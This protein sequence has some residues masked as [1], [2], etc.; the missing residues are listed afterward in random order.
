MKYRTKGIYSLLLFLAPGIKQVILKKLILISAIL[1]TAIMLQGQ[2]INVPADYTAIQEG[3]AAANQGD[4]VLVEPGTY[5]EN[6]NFLGKDITVASMYLF[7]RD[8]SIISQTI[9]DG[10]QNG[11]VVTFENGVTRDALLCGFTITNG[12]VDALE[13]GAGI[14]CESSDPSL[15][16]LIIS[17]NIVE[18][19]GDVY[20]VGI[21]CFN[22]FPYLEEIDIAENVIWETMGCSGLGMF[23]D[24]FS[25]AILKNVIIRNN[26]VNSYWGGYGGQLVF[27]NGENVELNNV[28][29]YSNGTF[30]SGIIIFGGTPKLI[31]IKVHGCSGSSGSIGLSGS[32]AIIINS[33]FT[34]NNSYGISASDSS[35]ILLQNV[36]IAGNEEY[37]IKVG[38][39]ELTLINCIVW[40]NGIEVYLTSDNSSISVLNSDIKGGETGI[41]GA[42][43][44]NWLEGNINEDPLFLGSG[45]H[46]YQLSLGSPCI[47]AGT[48]DTASLNLPEGDI[49]GNLRI[50][51]GNGDSDA[52]IDMGA[53]EFL[54][55]PVAVEEGEISR[56]PL[57]L[58]CYPNPFINF[59]TIEYKLSK[60]DMIV[61]TLFNS[62]GQK[63]M[64][65]VNEFQGEGMHQLKWDAGNLP[66][67]IYLCSLQIGNEMVA[68][69]IIKVQ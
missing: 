44:V 65:L 13:A 29:V 69:K 32:S 7:D 66:P 10:N 58:N 22:S 50:W 3:I 62:L 21:A 27:L 37:G 55:V 64:V 30:E 67:G 51:D 41:E 56:N 43:T 17:N 23:C 28:E 12:T 34:N 46:P 26:E 63:T 18:A 14:L 48:P 20:G 25:S 24:Y 47:D 16:N 61:V 57:G 5:Y 19:G 36:T 45:N 15:K 35:N 1:H 59:T 8:T 52:R 6:V 49:L 39:A 31:N 38:G 2:I 42:G 54:S 4:T 53:Y 40:N 11:R 68:K 33:E 9:I 60:P